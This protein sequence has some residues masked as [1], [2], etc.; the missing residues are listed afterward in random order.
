M[1]TNR[2]QTLREFTVWGLKTNGDMKLN[3][4][5]SNEYGATSLRSIEMSTMVKN[6]KIVKCRYTC[7]REEKEAVKKGKCSY[8]RLESKIKEWL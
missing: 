2:Y 3:R 4:M 1:S 5:E 6:I 8:F 7:E